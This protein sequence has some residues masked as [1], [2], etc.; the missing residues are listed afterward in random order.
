MRRIQEVH[1]AIRALYIESE[2]LLLKGD[3]TF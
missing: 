2:C 3:S 1:R